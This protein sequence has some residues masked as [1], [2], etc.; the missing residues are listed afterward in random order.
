MHSLWLE[1]R[2]RV[3]PWVAVIEAIHIPSTRAHASDRAN[4]VA[5]SLW[6]Q[7]MERPHSTVIKQQHLDLAGRRSPDP[8]ACPSRLCPGTNS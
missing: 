2:G 8:K 1:A 3:R 5:I 6:T 4:K 7:A